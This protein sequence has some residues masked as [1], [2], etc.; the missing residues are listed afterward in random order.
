MYCF[1]ILVA[2]VLGFPHSCY[3]F[4]ITFVPKSVAHSVQP[5][6]LCLKAQHG[7]NLTWLSLEYA[8]ASFA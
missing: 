5:N 1:V 3:A 8:S 4:S 6:V 7:F 2:A